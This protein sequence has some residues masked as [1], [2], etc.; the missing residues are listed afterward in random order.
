MK[1][2]VVPEVE[3]VVVGESR[4]FAASTKMS[5]LASAPIDDLDLVAEEIPGEEDTTEGG[6]ETEGGGDPV[7]EEASHD[8]DGAKE[9]GSNAVKEVAEA[10]AVEKAVEEN[11]S[12]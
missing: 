9:S 6:S 7:K 3:F 10:T 11:I 4:I 8:S 2:F 5:K 12:E 1:V